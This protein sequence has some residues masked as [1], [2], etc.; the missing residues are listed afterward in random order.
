MAK[1]VYPTGVENHGGKLRISFHYKGKRVRENLGVPDIPKNRKIA[2]ELRTA[3]CFAIKTGSFDYAAQFPDSPNLKMFGIVNKEITVAELAKKWLDLKKLEVSSN[4]MLRYESVIKN[5]VDLIGGKNT[6]SAITQEHL[7]VARKELLTGFHI[8]KKRQKKVI[9]GRRV[10]T[11]NNYMVITAGMFQFAVDARYI[12]K[13][14]FEGISLL[15]TSKGVPDPLTR[16][17]FARLM[18]ACYHQQV[19]NF[20]SLAV[21][22]GMR[23]GELCSLA[24]EDIDLMARTLTVRRNY[25]KAKEFTLPKTQA[26]T[27]RVIHLVQPAFDALK[28]QAELTR[29]GKQHRIEVKLRE[30]GRSTIHPCTF[31]FNPQITRRN[32][33]YEGYHYSVSSVASSWEMLMRRSGIRY[34][35]A[36]QSRHTYACWSL[37]A[38]A[39]PNFIANQMGHTNAQMVFNVYG[40][41]MSENNS[42]QIEILNKGLLGTA[43]QVSQEAIL[44]S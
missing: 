42:D 8:M 18:D 44:K 39:N 4:T 41:W 3:V 6:V 21:Y 34:R 19:K 14:P 27:D 11:V 38:G 10:T 31:V 24:W 35:K 7:L 2:G 43:P 36:Y 29:L 1:T 26:G 33:N 13:N 17:E 20:W 16:D 30:Y 15:R 28:K 40:T 9:K 22:T 12:D 25:T 37:A 32:N 5:M 23:H